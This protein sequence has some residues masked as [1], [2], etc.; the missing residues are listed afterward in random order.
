LNKFSSVYFTFLESIGI[1]CDKQILRIFAFN[2]AIFARR[3]SIV[4][5][6]VLNS[7]KLKYEFIEMFFSSYL[8][9]DVNEMVDLYGDKML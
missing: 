4:R 5:I 9:I 8:T 2:L 6:S 1:P 7:L 3:Q